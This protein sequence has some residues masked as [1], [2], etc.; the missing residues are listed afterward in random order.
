MVS[1]QTSTILQ[2]LLM[3]CVDSGLS[4]SLWVDKNLTD[5][6][7]TCKMDIL[8]LFENQCLCL[9]QSDLH[10]KEVM[11]QRAQRVRPGPVHDASI[12]LSPAE[13]LSPEHLQ[14]LRDAFT[15]VHHKLQTNGV[16]GRKRRTRS[17]NDPRVVFEEFCEVISLVFGSDAEVGWVKRFFE[18]VDIC[19]TGQVSMQQMYS[20]LLLEYSQRSRASV[21]A[22]ALLRT[23]QDSQQTIRH[24]SSNKR[25]PTVR[26]VAVFHPPSLRYISVSKCGQVTVWNKHLHITKALSLAGD[27]TEEV[28][29]TKRFRGW[30][31]DA[32]YMK[33]ARTVA[34]STDCRDIHFINVSTTNVFED[35]HLY[36]MYNVW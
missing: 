18:E 28:A 27:P 29:H 33:N 17:Q 20:Y 13:R 24:C 19:C 10:E 31:T 21:P 30:V 35:L 6:L 7:L 25:E 26:V 3:R 11:G 8:S 15:C 22:P 23:A 9:A 16:T 36:G 32:V 1:R 4:V 12:G 5:R 2:T 14:L 34:I